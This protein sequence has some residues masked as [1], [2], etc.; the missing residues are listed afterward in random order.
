MQKHLQIQRR[1]KTN[2]ETD[3]RTGIC[4]CDRLTGRVFRFFRHTA[5]CDA[6]ITKQLGSQSRTGRFP[7]DTFGTKRLRN[8]GFHERK[9]DGIL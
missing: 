2:F 5:I 4:A 6:G 3:K 9:T 1:N 7:R 8:G